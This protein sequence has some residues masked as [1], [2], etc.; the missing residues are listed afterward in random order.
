[1]AQNQ[2]RS[3]R[4]GSRGPRTAYLHSEGEDGDF[5]RLCV[6]RGPGPAASDA[7]V[8]VIERDTARGG[9]YREVGP[10]DPSRVRTREIARQNRAA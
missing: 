10:G 2:A 9:R 3:D 4:V 1:M 7:R 6:T 5:D 8:V